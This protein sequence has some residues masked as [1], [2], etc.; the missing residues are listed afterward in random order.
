MEEYLV[1]LSKYNRMYITKLRT[2]FNQLPF[3]IDRHRQISREE[4]YCTKCDVGQVG[5]EFHVLLQCQS[6][7]IVQLGNTYVLEYYL[8]RLNH[9]NF[10]ELV[11][12]K[13][14]E[15]ITNF[16]QFIKCLLGLFR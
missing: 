13:N 15:L 2:G 14:T 1:E 6:Q 9:Y 8:I 7:D 11:Q 5:D 16:A 12:R 4:R 10:A 3:I